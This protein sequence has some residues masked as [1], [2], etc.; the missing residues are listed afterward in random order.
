MKVKLI[1]W[2][3]EHQKEL[4]ELCNR[5]ERTYLSLRIPQPYSRQDAVDWLTM[6]QNEEGKSGLFRAVTVDDTIVGTISL[7]QKA[8]VYSVDAEIG[9][10]LDPGLRKQGIMTEAVRQMVPLGFDRLDIKRITGKVYAPNSPSR[11][12]LE[13]NG[14]QLEGIMKK[15]ARRH[16]ELYDVCIYGRIKNP[17]D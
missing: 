12:V 9:Y 6:V 7:E 11:K 13:A 14:F 10:F 15:A 16:D 2:T 4:V 3:L 5:V 8:D 17:I 1:H